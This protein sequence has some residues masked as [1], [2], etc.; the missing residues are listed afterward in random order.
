MKSHISGFIPILAA[1][2]SVFWVRSTLADSTNREVPKAPTPHHGN[3]VVIVNDDGF[4]NFYSGKYRTSDDLRK[5][6]LA[7]KDTQVGVQEWCFVAGSRVNF[8]SKNHKLVGEGAEKYGRRGDELAAITLRNLHEEGS[9][10]L[11]IVA[12][13]CH[14]VGIACYA[15]MR[16]NGDYSA[17]AWGGDMAKMFNSDFWWDHPE[18]HQRSA[19]DKPLTRLSYA[20]L[21]ISRSAG[22]QAWSHPRG[23]GTGC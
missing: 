1:L 14:E 18:F 8:P 10:T 22:I 5:H 19:A 21:C 11:S 9:D 20:F 23:R 13:A 7:Y 17:A 12:G 15:S 4:S 6:V 2:S 16:M 3:K